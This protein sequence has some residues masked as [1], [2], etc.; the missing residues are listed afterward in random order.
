MDEKTPAHEIYKLQQR[1]EKTTA[2]TVF[3]RT[4]NT[5]LYNQLKKINETYDTLLFGRRANYDD[6]LEYFLENTYD[7]WYN[8]DKSLHLKSIYSS[9][10]GLYRKWKRED[11][12]YWITHENPEVLFT[13]NVENINYMMLSKNKNL[14]IQTVVEHKDRRWIWKSVFEN[15][16]LD[17]DVMKMNPEIKWDFCAI[18]KNRSVTQEM[19]INYQNEKWDYKELS[20][21]IG[22]KIVK[23][24]P[25]KPWDYSN[26]SNGRRRYWKELTS[27][28]GEIERCIECDI[29]EEDVTNNLDIAWD[30]KILGDNPNIKMEYILTNIDKGWNFGKVSMNIHFDVY[31]KKTMENKKKDINWS[32]GNTY[33]IIHSNTKIKEWEEYL[34][35]SMEE[36]H[37]GY[38]LLLSY[39]PNLPIDMIY[40]NPSRRWDYD[41]VLRRGLLRERMDYI[42]KEI[43]KKSI[44]LKEIEKRRYNN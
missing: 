23:I 32:K 27:V 30:Y 42:M 35:S 19:V 2:Y 43:E 14:K 16:Q 25:D 24:L 7:T 4:F 9:N 22:W 11:F 39:N 3:N 31:Y 37:K 38:F 44:Y 36:D 20:R 8:Y 28:E 17:L 1:W 15:V 33:L 12:M 6:N 10:I 26:I 29:T 21:H 34:N 5:I 40:G 18:S 41:F 13:F